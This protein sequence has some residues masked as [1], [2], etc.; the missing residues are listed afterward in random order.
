MA[1]RVS[2]PIVIE[3][4]LSADAYSKLL[5]VI[6]LEGVSADWDEGPFEPAD[7]TPG[8][9]LRLCAHEV[10]WGRFQSLEDWLLEAGLPFVRWAGGCAG[11]FGPERVIATGDGMLNVCAV[12]DDDEVVLDRATIDQLGSMDAIRAFFTAADFQVPPFHVEGDAPW[13][14]AQS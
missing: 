5:E 2:A 14:D 9:P 3:G 4:S 10:A 13:P 8:Q 1:D 11:S 6:A 12:T 7:R